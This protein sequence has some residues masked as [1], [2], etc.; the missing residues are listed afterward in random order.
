MEV[1]ILSKE[2]RRDLIEDYRSLDVTT[3]HETTDSCPQ[4][5][6]SLHINE[7]EIFTSASNVNHFSA[8]LTMFTD[9]ASQSLDSEP[10]IHIYS[11][12]KNQFKTID[13]EQ[14]NGSAIKSNYSQ[15]MNKPRNRFSGSKIQL[16]SVFPADSF[17]GS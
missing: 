15:I 9:F 8:N 16:S 12:K 4:I 7:R 14:L 2:I 13:Y 3:I 17:N 1:V 11:N 5:K 10:V 6:K